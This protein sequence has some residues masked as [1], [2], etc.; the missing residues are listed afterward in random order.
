MAPFS[1]AQEDGTVDCAMDSFPERNREAEPR[2]NSPTVLAHHPGSSEEGRNP[3][4]V[5]TG[6]LEP[7][8]GHS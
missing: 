7:K 5:E 1:G 6:L 8:R 4:V 2:R 3:G